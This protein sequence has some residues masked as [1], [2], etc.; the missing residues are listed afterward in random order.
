M[1]PRS[2]P[3][4]SGC[5]RRWRSSPRSARGTANQLTHLD[6]V[7]TL[8]DEQPDLDLRS[9][10]IDA[11][12]ARSGATV[13]PEAV[14]EAKVLQ[15][16]SRISADAEQ[17]RLLLDQGIHSAH[18]VCHARAR[19]A[20]RPARRRRPH[21]AGGAHRVGHRPAPLRPGDHPPRRLPQRAEPGEPE[22]DRVVH[23]HRRRAAHPVRRRAR[24]GDAVR[25]RRRVRLLV[26]RVGARAT[27][28]PRR[29]APLPRRACR[30]RPPA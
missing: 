16:V 22:G 20:R 11:L 7:A 12:V 9:T 23:V 2:R 29:P 24:P 21:R 6:A 17:G 8:A 25:A 5:T 18:Q 14:A 30:R 19:P 13:A 27:G 1:R 3:R 28:V 4:P 15:R 26:V 10:N